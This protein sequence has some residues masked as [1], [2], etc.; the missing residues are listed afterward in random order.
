MNEWMDEEMNG[1]MTER[2]M[3]NRWIDR[4]W[5]N[6]WTGRHVD[7]QIDEWMDV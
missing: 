5:R 3:N 7:S 6:G 4:F 1:Q 2:K